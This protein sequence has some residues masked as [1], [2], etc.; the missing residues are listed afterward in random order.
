[1]RLHVLAQH[2]IE[3]GHALGPINDIMDTLHVANKGRML[4]TLERFYIYKETQL[5]TQIND[6]LAVQSNPIFNA[7]PPY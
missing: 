4:D 1:M 6:K 5:W 3:E 2:V 7:P